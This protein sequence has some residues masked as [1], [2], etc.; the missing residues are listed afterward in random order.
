MVAAAVLWLLTQWLG[1]V[2]ARG[3]LGSDAREGVH[4]LCERAEIALTRGGLDEARELL[5]IALSMDDERVEV[6]R[7]WARLMMLLGRFQEARRAWRTVLCLHPAEA[8]RR[9]AIDC[10]ERMPGGVMS[11]GTVTP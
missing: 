2:R 8:L 10:L 7:L 11:R 6:Q 9:E 3:I 4:L 1:L 5:V